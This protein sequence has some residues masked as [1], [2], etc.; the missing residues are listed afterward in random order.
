MFEF[1]VL[2]LIPG[3]EVRI[4]FSA[5]ILISTAILLYL[6]RHNLRRVVILAQK[7]WALRYLVAAMT[8][9]ATLSLKRK[10]QG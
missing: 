2:G 5:W 6:N 7:I 10:I 8:S 9:L 4:S 1:L 3:T